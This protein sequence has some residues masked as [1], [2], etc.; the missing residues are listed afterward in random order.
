MA[1]IYL[2]KPYFTVQPEDNTLETI[3]KIV[4]GV[5]LG[6]VVL[7]IAGRQV[8]K[9]RRRRGLVRVSKE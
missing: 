9:C 5:V 7:L 3:L 1:F 8:K 6:V 4:G 2:L